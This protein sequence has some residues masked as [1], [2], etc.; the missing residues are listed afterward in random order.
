[1]SVP[2]PARDVMLAQKSYRMNELLVNAFAASAPWEDW[3]EWLDPVF[4]AAFKCAHGSFLD[5]G[6][7]LGQTL[8]K[9]LTYDPARQYIGFDPQPA[10]CFMV[11]RFIDENRLT[12]CRIV[13]VGLYDQNGIVTLYGGAEDFSALST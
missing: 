4:E 10:C 7:N 12:N 8:L 9:M 1:M 6:V 13:P 11:Q 5:V 2:L 3:E